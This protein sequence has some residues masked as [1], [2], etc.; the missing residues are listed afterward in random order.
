MT[1]TLVSLLLVTARKT[2]PRFSF[3]TE[4]KLCAAILF[5]H[6]R[7]PMT[8]TTNDP[9]ELVQHYLTH[10]YRVVFWPRSGDDKGPR[11]RGWTQARYTL[12]DYHPGDRVGLVTGHE[13]EPGKFLHDV[14]LDWAPGS[15]IAQ[16]FLPATDFVFGRASKKISHCFYTLPETLPTF[17]YKDIDDGTLIELRGSKLDGDVGFQTMAPPSVWTKKG[18]EEPLQFVKQGAPAHIP[19]AAY[20]KQRV[21]YAAIGMILAKHLGTN[22]FGHDSRLA[23]AGFLLR[24]GMAVEDLVTM[25]EAISTYCNNQEVSDVRRVVESTVQA[26]NSTS[27][28]VKGG[29]TLARLLG[30]AGK[31]ILARINEW[32]GKERDFLRGADGGI[33]KDNQENI[34]RAISLMGHD[35]AY[36]E[37]SDKMFL[38]RAK[39]V[40]DREMT[41]LWLRIDEAYRFRPTYMFFEKVVKQIAWDNAFHPVKEYLATLDWD[42]TARVGGWLQHAAGAEDSAYVRAVGSILLIAAVRRI[43]HPGSKFD[44]LL[45]LEGE[46]GLNKSSALRALCPKGE[47]FSDDLPLNVQAQRMIEGTLGKWIIEA[48]DLAGKRKAD[49]EQLKATLSRQVDGPARMAYAHLPVERARQFV[50]VGTTNSAAYL[51]DPT[52]ARRFWPVAIQAFDVGWI[53]EHRDQLW[54][55]AAVLEEK[56]ASTRLAESLWPDAALEQEERR[57][58]D[59][60]ETILRPL[61]Q[62]TEVT[63][64]GYR[65]IATD[66][67]WDALGIEAARRDRY[68]ALRISETMQRLGFVRTRLRLPEV[69][70]VVGYINKDKSHNEPVEDKL[71]PAHHREV[72]GESEGETVAAVAKKEE[73]PF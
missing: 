38:D 60:W 27:K 5:C 41:S 66:A 8:D 14:D 67:L 30:P 19:D 3:S 68:G 31:A 16:F 11:I 48:A 12:E 70:V 25:G 64:G 33:L 26:L 36:D 6:A 49:I 29:P 40:E 20:L 54:A 52:G 44:E 34:K 56:G 43:R 18:V 10:H 65:R 15:L 69:G 59:P 45:V 13:L 71:F 4:N 7:Y 1:I 63:S 37:F 62:G 55:E 50:I 58:I 22:G 21:C 28:K 42:G 47:W 61:L 2:P 9:Q 32:L 57:E 17:Q 46:Q 53:L 39:V 72:E 51:S 73:V 24:A 23:W 35:L